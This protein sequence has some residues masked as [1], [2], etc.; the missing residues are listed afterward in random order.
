MLISNQTKAQTDSA[1]LQKAQERVAEKIE[2]A[3]KHQRKIDKRQ[4]KIE[5]Q[6]KKIN[7]QER[8]RDR[9][10]RKAKKEQRKLNDD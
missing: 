7:R 9:D 5:K 10:L 3:D 8:R 1:G 2:D 6:Q 4:R